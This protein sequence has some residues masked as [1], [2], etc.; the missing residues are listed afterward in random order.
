MH[1]IHCTL[2][3]RTI[4]CLPLPGSPWSLGRPCCTQFSTFPQLRVN[5]WIESQLPLHLPPKLPPRDW[6]PPST[7]PIS[8]DHGLQ[9]HLDTRS[10]RA[11]K[12]ISKL[13]RLRTPSVSL[14][15]HYHD[16]QD[17]TITASKCISKLACLQPSSASQ[18]SLDYGLQVRM[19]TASKCIFKLAWLRPPSVSPNSLDHGLEVHL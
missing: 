18:N 12:C 13:A 9:V 16:L 19:I 11:S 6:P 15:S 17:R 3:H 5:H 14:N 4:D 2:H 7:L 10:I 8:L 1:C